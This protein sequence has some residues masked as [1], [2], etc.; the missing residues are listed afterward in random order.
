MDSIFEQVVFDENDQYDSFSIGG[1]ESQELQTNENNSSE[2][3]LGNENP[4]D[5][6]NPDDDKDF[7][8]SL[9]L[10][11][12]VTSDG[13]IDENGDPEPDDDDDVDK[14]IEKLKAKGFNVDKPEDI[15]PSVEYKNKREVLSSRV[16]NL[17]NFLKS[18]DD[19]IIKL[20]MTNELK[21][22]YH[23]E[24]K[25]HLIGSEDFN[26]ELEANLN[27]L[28]FTTRSVLLNNFKSQIQNVISKDE[29]EIK[30]LDIQERNRSTSLIKENRQKLGREF[31][32][33]FKNGQFLGVPL[34]DGS[35]LKEAYNDVVNKRLDSKFN[36][37]Q[38]VTEVALYLRLRDKLIENSG[39]G[40]YGEGVKSAFDAILKG[41]FSSVSKN[42]LVNA[43]DKTGRDT[44]GAA[45]IGD[46]DLKS[47]WEVSI[48]ENKKKKEEN[49]SIS[50][51]YSM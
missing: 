23:K 13:I 16:E 19:V 43:V 50:D 42:P 28:N 7:E 37:P 22:L 6:K 32:K 14:M 9:G 33:I 4:D 20:G 26:E 47:H 39:K 29:N 24:N 10:E 48:E 31:N 21:A 44:S 51:H 38:V 12:D 30:E 15:D 5:K 18:D 36:D 8:N 11:L 45:G 25:A 41:D 17:K 49:K 27:D 35:I 3:D 1:D 46:I 2:P 34:G 40:T